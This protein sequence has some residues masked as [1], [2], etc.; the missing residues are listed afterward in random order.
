M[1]VARLNPRLILPEVCLH[2]VSLTWVNLDAYDW[3]EYIKMVTV[4]INCFSMVTLLHKKKRFFSLKDLLHAFI[5]RN[6]TNF[7][8][9][10]YTKKWVFDGR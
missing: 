8:V 4:K 7:R 6:K 1:W 3:L 9:S 10:V 2:L 5:T